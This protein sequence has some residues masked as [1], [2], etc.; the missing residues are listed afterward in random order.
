MSLLASSRAACSR[1]QVGAI[2]TSP[3]N[4]LISEGYNGT[5]SGAAHCGEGGCPRGELTYDECPPN[6]D[7]N[8]VPCYGLHAEHQAILYAGIEK[9]SGAILY[10]TCEPCTQCWVLIKAVDISK[11][12]GPDGEYVNTRI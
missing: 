9:C 8:A 3:G 2:L 10:V 4:R 7:Y 5:R 12:I 11:V 6:T 1:R